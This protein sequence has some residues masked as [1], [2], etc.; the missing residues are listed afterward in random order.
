MYKCYVSILKINFTSIF[1]ALFKNENFNKYL[2]LINVKLINTKG[3]PFEK[4][5]L[6]EIIIILLVVNNHCSIY[7]YIFNSVYFSY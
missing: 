6:F 4:R 5:L 1:C 2:I 7:K 3:Q